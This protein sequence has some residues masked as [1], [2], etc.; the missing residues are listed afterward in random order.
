MSPS[1]DLHSPISSRMEPERKL[2][3]HSLDAY[4]RSKDQSLPTL[5]RSPQATPTMTKDNSN[6][7]KKTAGINF[8][9]Q[10]DTLRTL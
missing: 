5:D 3:S 7:E 9:I 6:H 4:V 2:P 8:E 10:K 1:I